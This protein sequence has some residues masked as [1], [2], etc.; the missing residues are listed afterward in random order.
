MT[1]NS[2]HNRRVSLSDLI[3]LER[4]EIVD[5]TELS[6]L[7]RQSNE[8]SLTSVWSN[9]LGSDEEWS[10]AS[11][12]PSEI[13]TWLQQLLADLSTSRI[14]RLELSDSQRRDLHDGRSITV[15][16]A[17]LEE[18]NCK[19]SPAPNGVCEVTFHGLAGK[20]RPLNFTF[21]AVSAPT[22][23][24]ELVQAELPLQW[25]KEAL[26]EKVLRATRT[27]PAAHLAEMVDSLA[28]QSSDRTRSPADLKLN[29]LQLNSVEVQ[30]T[31][32]EG[33]LARAVSLA[34]EFTINGAK[35]VHQQNLVLSAAPA[36]PGKLVAV[37]DI[38]FP[39]G[40]K[41]GFKLVTA[42]E[43][44]PEEFSRL[45][46]D[47]VNELLSH[48]SNEALPL[49]LL[50]EGKFAVRLDALLATQTS[51]TMFLRYTDQGQSASAGPLGHSADDR[52]V[53]IAFNA[54]F[55][56]HYPAAHSFA[57]YLASPPAPADDIL[58]Q[59]AL[60]AFTG[61]TSLVNK[62]PME[63]I[64][65]FFGGWFNVIMTRA[66]RRMSGYRKVRGV[67]NAA[68]TG[69]KPKFGHPFLAMLNSDSKATSNETESVGIVENW[70]DS[71]TMTAS[72]EVQRQQDVE[73]LRDALNQLSEKEREVLQLRYFE[74][75]KLKEISEITGI[76]MGTLGNFLNQAKGKLLTHL[77]GDEQL[78][79]QR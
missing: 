67:A 59:A 68:E 42:R 79:A 20:L 48:G 52:A 77:G 49:E 63:Q 16:I 53:K 39:A 1:G 78:G 4:G 37:Y 72:E 21:A 24:P 17:G 60:N 71:R 3:R 23:F 28:C 62:R 35:V 26:E 61:F 33:E 12:A 10:D 36:D 50:G 7:L 22:R 11:A 54:L 65:L 73:H 51:Q 69:P 6:W 66:A 25:P 32:A 15:E 8:D 76:P 31:A 40:A 47:T 58:Q 70:P 5:S 41:F 27:E 43:L 18:A 14:A 64:K 30:A 34:V 57:N 38:P 55:Q 74:G 46:T 45:D 19:F 56:S 2:Q 29:H 75:L 13:Q 44:T 9:L